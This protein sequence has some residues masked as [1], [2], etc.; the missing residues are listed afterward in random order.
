MGKD[1]GLQTAAEILVSHIHSSQFMSLYQYA[2]FFSSLD[3][4]GTIQNSPKISPKQQNTPKQAARS[5]YVNRWIQIFWNSAELHPSFEGAM[6]LTEHIWL[7]FICICFYGT[8]NMN[9]KNYTLLQ[10]QSAL[11]VIYPPDSD[12]LLEPTSI[13]FRL[14]FIPACKFWCEGRRN[15]FKYCELL[16]TGC[17]DG[18]AE[19]ELQQSFDQ[20]PGRHKCRESSEAKCQLSSKS[21]LLHLSKE[22]THSRHI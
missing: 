20:Q 17:M 22:K 19:K 6:K 12:N 2:P 7:C 16:T 10:T 5:I 18:G 3:E 9:M 21:L 8:C 15:S 14:N 13:F 4:T 1:W 11:L